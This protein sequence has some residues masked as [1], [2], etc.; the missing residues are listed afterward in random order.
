MECIIFSSEIIKILYEILYIIIPKD[1]CKC[2]NK[3]KNDCIYFLSFVPLFFIYFL[4]FILDI[5]NHNSI[6]EHYDYLKYNWKTNPISSIEI[7][8]N[9]DYELGKIIIQNEE[10]K[11]YEWKNKTFKI[12]RINNFDYYN[13]YESYNSKICG[14]D[15]FGNNLYFPEDIE[16]P[17]NDIIITT[18]SSLESYNKLPLG[19][20]VTYLYYTNK[21]IEKNIIIDLRAS[22]QITSYDKLY[23]QLNLDKSNDLC[24]F[25]ANNN[26]DCQRNKKDI[27]IPFYEILDIWDASSFI[28]IN[29]PINSSRKNVSLNSI[30]YQGINSSNFIERRILLNFKKH[31]DIFKI[32]II[33]KYISVIINV[34]SLIFINIFLSQKKITKKQV[35]I[36]IILLILIIIIIIIYSFSLIIN[37]KYIKGFIEKIFSE[38]KI[39]KNEYILGIIILLYEFLIFL[40]LLC[41]TNFTLFFKGNSHL[42]N[43][44]NNNNNNNPQEIIQGIIKGVNK[45]NDGKFPAQ[46]FKNKNNSEDKEN[47]SNFPLQVQNPIILNIS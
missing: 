43:N 11:F 14:K 9:K 23:I 1:C 21:K 3:N 39:E 40:S 47:I 7:N 34:T 15:S 36:T 8:N 4:F 27:S 26:I 16:C 28:N 2:Q 38:L 6:Q 46:L 24:Y 12:N 17:I 20:N 13:I 29:K 42:N 5:D 45:R 31:M 37:I 10:Y 32:I 44:N 41:I 25:L 18:N 22:Y 30:Y 19:D 33:F 35:I